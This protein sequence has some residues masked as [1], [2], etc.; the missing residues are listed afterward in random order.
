MTTYSRISCLKWDATGEL[1]MEDKTG[2]TAESP[3]DHCRKDD[4]EDKATHWTKKQNET[5]PA[6]TAA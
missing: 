6:S 1:C 5:I 2:F 4:T 3:K